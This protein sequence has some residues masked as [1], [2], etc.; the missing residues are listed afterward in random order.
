MKLSELSTEINR[1]LEDDM[2]GK[3]MAIIIVLWM[4]GLA[5][6][7]VIAFVI[8]HVILGY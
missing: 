8:I 2:S 3:Q 4:G 1:I 6:F 7:G 5:V